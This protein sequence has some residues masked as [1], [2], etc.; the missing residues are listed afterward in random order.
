MLVMA[1]PSAAGEQDLRQRLISRDH[2]AFAELY[3]QFAPEVHQMAL[4]VAGDSHAAHDI[5]QEVFLQAWDRPASFDPERGSMRTWLGLLTHTTAVR[6]LRGREAEARKV[7]RQEAERYLTL[8]PD[9]VASARISA[10]RARAALHRLPPHQRQALEL[11]YV[12]GLTYR[13]VAME[14]G[15]PEGT[16]KSRMRLGLGHL[17]RLLTA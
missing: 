15:I 7:Q 5:A 8:G 16:A 1:P 14:L 17:A 3:G 6:W 11:A 12:E 10:Q 9:D 4:R 2:D 13:Q